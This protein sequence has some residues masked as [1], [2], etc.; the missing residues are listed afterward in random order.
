LSELLTMSERTLLIAMNKEP[1]F[2]GLNN[3]DLLY[4]LTEE[5]IRSTL[6]NSERTEELLRIK[7]EM[8]NE[9]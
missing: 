9:F 7:K 5:I 1:R 2:R 6:G 4:M 3:E 8:E